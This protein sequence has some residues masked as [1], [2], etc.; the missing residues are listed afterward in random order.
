MKKTDKFLSIDN[1]IVREII[2]NIIDEIYSI[3]QLYAKKYDEFSSLTNKLNSNS[4]VDK[5][6]QLTYNQESSISQLDTAIYNLLGNL[7]KKATYEKDGQHCSIMDV[8]ASIEDIK[9]AQT[10]VENNIDYYSKLISDNTTDTNPLDKSTMNNFIKLF[11]SIIK[12]KLID[13]F[14]K[15]E[16]FDITKALGLTLTPEDAFQ[17]VYNQNTTEEE[18]QEKLEENREEIEELKNDASFDSI[19]KVDIEELKEGTSFDSVSP[20]E[21]QTYLEISTPLSATQLVNS[22]K[23]ESEVVVYTDGMSN[24]IGEKAQQLLDY[25]VLLEM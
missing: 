17:S 14:P 7:R 11:C 5:V 16:A 10:I 4:S 1:E 23:I 20:E 15:A 18:V 6:Q 25:N 9:K 24:L 21:N 19:E 12:E 13:L 2:S 3:A 8:G 22:T